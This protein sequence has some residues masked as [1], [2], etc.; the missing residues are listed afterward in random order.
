[1]GPLG[2][3]A[4][5]RCWIPLSI[6]WLVPSLAS[7][8]LNKL[9][10]SVDFDHEECIGD[11]CF[12]KNQV[13]QID[14]AKTDKSGKLA[15]NEVSL[16]YVSTQNLLDVCLPGVKKENVA[17]EFKSCKGKKMEEV[18]NFAKRGW[19]KKDANEDTVTDIDLLK[20]IVSGLDGGDESVKKCVKVKEEAEAYDDDYYY[21]YDYYDYDYGYDY[22]EEM[23]S[24]LNRKKRG[25]RKD[26]KGKRRSKKNNGKNSRKSKGKKAK[27]PRKN[28]GKKG[29]KSR[30]NKGKKPRKN[31]QNKRKSKGKKNNKKGNRNRKNKG[32]KNNKKG[33]KNNRKG[34]KNNKKGKKKNKKGNKNNKKEKK[35]GNNDR[36]YV[37]K[38][39]QESSPENTAK[40]AAKLSKLGLT[41][42]PTKSTLDELNCMWEEL[43]GLLSKCGSKMAA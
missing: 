42:L 1:M 40:I 2:F 30:K 5:M 27:K 15:Y 37:S 16:G 18:C 14:R 22:L 4:T 34:K 20:S 21:D 26:G 39:N 17:E 43:E 36:K 29:Q 23:G 35:K 10:P 12:L 13:L 11:A 3:S 33:K 31:R 7:D 8:F 19:L 9:I 25:A 28:K 24:G 41:K 38:P 6:V 32:K